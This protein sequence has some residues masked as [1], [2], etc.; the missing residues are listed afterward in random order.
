MT[1]FSSHA[2]LLL[3]YG[4]L[5][6][7]NGWF[8]GLEVT[9]NRLWIGQYWI[10][11]AVVCR[12]WS[13]NLLLGLLC[14]VFGLKGIIFFLKNQYEDAVSLQKQIC[15]LISSRLMSLK[16]YPPSQANFWLTKEWNLPNSI[17]KLSLLFF[18]LMRKDPKGLLMPHARWKETNCY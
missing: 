16:K 13:W 2:P 9:G 6:W 14:T 3:E 5:C 18:L 12:R 7:A 1:T 11:R 17:L 4:N 10:W 15:N 8:V